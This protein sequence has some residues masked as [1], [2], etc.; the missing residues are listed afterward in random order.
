MALSPTMNDDLMRV[1]AEMRDHTRAFAATISHSE[2][3]D[4]GEVLGSG[5]YVELRGNVYLL[6][7]DHVA[8]KTEHSILAHSP[9]GDRPAITLGQPF[10]STTCPI[11]AAVT[12]LDPASFAD[13]TKLALPAN[14]IAQRFDPAKKEMLFIQGFPERKSHF[15]ALGNVLIAKSLPYLTQERPLPSGHDPKY[16]F[17]LDY[18]TNEDRGLGGDLRVNFHSDAELVI[19]PCVESS[20]EADGTHYHGV[21]DGGIFI[22]CTIVGGG[23]ERAKAVPLLVT[24]AFY[25]YRIMPA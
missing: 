14:R 7:N 18:P 9:S 5:T 12:I 23:V 2:N 25:Q 8:Q 10:H 4:A 21:Y 15:S 24:H 6:T 1:M 3:L 22:S 16:S 17:A 11:D 19:K 20:A 13:G